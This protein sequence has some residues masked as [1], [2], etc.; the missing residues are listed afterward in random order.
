[1]DF[2][3]IFIV[4]GCCISM[5]VLIV[6][7][8]VLINSFSLFGLFGKFCTQLKY[9]GSNCAVMSKLL[10]TLVMVFKVGLTTFRI[11]CY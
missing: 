5:K 7:L 1:M 6:E 9:S 8:P 3:K 2:I 10:L 4:F 11:I